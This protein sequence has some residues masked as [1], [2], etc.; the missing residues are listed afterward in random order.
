MFD[1]FDT[2]KD[3]KYFEKYGVW[4]CV[5]KMTVF[6]KIVRFGVNFSKILENHCFSRTLLKQ[7]KKIDSIDYKL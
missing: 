7:V 6:Q 2:I 3:I 4:N 5:C 1:E